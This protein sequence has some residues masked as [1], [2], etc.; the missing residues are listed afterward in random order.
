MGGKISQLMVRLAELAEAEG[1]VFKEHFDRLF[2]RVLMLLGA[3]L[4][5]LAGLV[6]L[7]IGVYRQLAEIT[8][9]AAAAMLLGLGL[10]LLG[11]VLFA[12]ASALA[13]NLPGDPRGRRNRS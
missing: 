13:G 12:L 6:V 3:F 4:V 11:G 9:P 2:Q 5:A 8:T 10:L 1:R 7:A